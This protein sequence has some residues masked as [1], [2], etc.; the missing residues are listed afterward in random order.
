M[1][2][3]GPVAPAEIK[4]CA[5]HEPSVVVHFRSLHIAHDVWIIAKLAVVQLCD[6]HRVAGGLELRPRRHQTDGGGSEGDVFRA[7]VV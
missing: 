2:F 1:R 6:D 5:V 7:K 3:G 4:R